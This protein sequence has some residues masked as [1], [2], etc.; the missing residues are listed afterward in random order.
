MTAKKKYP[1]WCCIRRIIGKENGKP[2]SY[3]LAAIDWHTLVRHY[4][5]TA[6]SK[7]GI[8]VNSTS[9]EKEIADHLEKRGY[10][11]CFPL[12]EDKAKKMESIITG[13]STSGSATGTNGQ[14]MFSDTEEATS[15]SDDEV[16]SQWTSETDEEEEEEGE[17]A[18]QN[19]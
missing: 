4:S 5:P 2:V 17:E 14:K 8:I 11:V 16:S 1:P 18:S 15:S 13:Y 12:N 6:V 10:D 19:M 3:H 9:H 7:M